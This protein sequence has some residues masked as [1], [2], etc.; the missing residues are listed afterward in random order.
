[1]HV[2]KLDPR[3]PGG[4]ERFVDDL[5]TA[6]SQTGIEAHAVGCDAPDYGAKGDVSY[7]LT[8]ARTWFTVFHLPLA[9]GFPFA[10]VR[11]IDR[12]KPDVIH[13]HWP[14]PL[15][16]NLAAHVPTDARLVLHWHADIDPMGAS[17]PI[18]V[19]YGAAVRRFEAKL[20]SRADAIIATSHAYAAASP[21]LREVMDKVH[22]VPLALGEPV[23]TVA[24][25][26]WP[27]PGRP[28]VLF[29]GRAVP[30]KSLDVLL[31]A[32]AISLDACLVVVGDGPESGRWKAL[33]TRLNLDSRVRFVGAVDEPTKQS[34]L[35]A[36]DVLCLPSSNRLEAFGVVLLEAAAARRPVLVADIPGSGVAEV[37]RAI[38]GSS[39]FPVG[40]SARLAQCLLD[41]PLEN[42]ALP[43]EN[44]AFDIH[45]V[46]AAINTIYIASARNR[47][48]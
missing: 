10:I 11:A 1:M 16:L 17:L 20:V 34:L 24:P 5:L 28:R 30:Y 21:V 7:E 43:H 15:V 13:V 35:A 36:C 8:L 2:I 19:A 46:A 14:N 38:P 25:V 44:P 27:M 22:V 3:V 42:R 31:E 47:D 26:V 37:A 4:I 33:A 39:I 23:A 48:K 18:R 40:D 9:P 41:Y 29:V 6:Q 45:G 32:I 12:L